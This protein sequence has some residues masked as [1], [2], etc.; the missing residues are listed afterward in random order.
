MRLAGR[1][2]KHASDAGGARRT[3]DA[4]ADV[5]TGTGKRSSPDRAPLLIALGVIDDSHTGFLFPHYHLPGDSSGPF[6]ILQHDL[7]F[8]YPV[9]HFQIVYIR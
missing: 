1:E 7:N 2:W 4:I 9:S 6:P 8:E 3:K 5:L